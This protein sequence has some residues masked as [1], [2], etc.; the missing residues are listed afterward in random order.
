M[1]M[2]QDR[3]T[4]ERLVQR[5]IWVAQ[6]SLPQS[7]NGVDDHQRSELSARQDIVSD[8][9]FAIDVGFNAS[10]EALV[11]AAHESEAVELRELLGE[12]LVEGSPPCAQEKRSLGPVGFV[13]RFDAF[14]DRIGLHHHAASPAEGEVI[15][16][17]MSVMSVL[18]DIMEVDAHVALLAGASQNRALERTREEAGKECEDM[19]SHGGVLNPA[20]PRRRGP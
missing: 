4:R 2:L 18:S 14:D 13:N 5:R 7:R 12:V 19:E 20:G 8:R 17:P 16:G 3:F 6:H 11:M 1:G 10:V 9:D 15:D